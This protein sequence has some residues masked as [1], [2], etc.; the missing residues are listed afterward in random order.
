MNELKV[1]EM[2]LRPGRPKVAVPVVSSRPADIIA[3][4]EELKNLPCDIAEWRADYYLSAIEDLDGYLSDKNG[5]LDMVKILDDMNYI[6]DDKPLIFTVRSESQGGRVQMTKA[7]LESIYG[8]AAETRLVDFIDIELRDREGNIHEDW[9][10]EQI[11]ETHAHGVKVILSHHDFE[12]MPSPG[13]IVETVKKMH[14][15][16]AD[17]CKF[18]AMTKNRMDSENLLKATAFLTKKNIGPIIMLAMGDAGKAARV[19]A[20]RYGSCLTF[21]SGKEESAPGQVDTYTMKKWLDGYYGA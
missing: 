6:A 8:I 17:L 20:G 7:Q 13:E 16:G 12:A 18:A 14:V 4:C 1:R 21:A 2:I 3:E 15:L 11:D 10:R 9:I 19:A 5:Y